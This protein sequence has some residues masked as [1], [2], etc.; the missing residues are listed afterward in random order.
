M[1]KIAVGSSKRPSP[2]PDAQPAS[3][4]PVPPGRE[5]ETLPS[6]DQ[7]MGTRS[8]YLEQFAGVIKLRRILI[9][10][11]AI[12]RGSHPKSASSQ[13]GLTPLETE[14]IELFVGISR[15]F[16]QPR[17]VAEIYGLL[18]L[19]ERPLAMDDFIERLQLSKGSASMGLKYLRNM[20]AIKP[21]DLP[22]ARRVHYVAVAELRNLLSA[23][24]RDQFVPQLDA[25][26]VR[27]EKIS[28]LVKELPAADRD[29]VKARVTMLQ[30]WGKRGTKFLP[31]VVKI[32]GG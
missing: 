11:P 2:K 3:E 27:L 26:R 31:M 15:L 5:P 20:G 29:R 21:A 9:R 22:E 10:P 25:H 23:F 1:K 7:R 19:S 12:I 28:S 8:K 14:V 16:G 24:L 30:S 6:V 17:S 13:P 32:M 4:K 18:F